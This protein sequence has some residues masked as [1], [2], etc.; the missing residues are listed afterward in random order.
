[1]R[2]TARQLVVALLAMVVLLSMAAMLSA[3]RSCPA[4]G[5][6]HAVL[7]RR[8]RHVSGPRRDRKQ[9]R[10]CRT[11]GFITARTQSLPSDWRLITTCATM[12]G[13]AAGALISIGQ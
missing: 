7:Y 13:L 8:R 12:R 3:A 2:R 10:S 6:I 1:M 11:P 5:R 9:R 4:I